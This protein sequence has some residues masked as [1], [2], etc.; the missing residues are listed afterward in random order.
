V[1]TILSASFWSA[2]TAKEA[3]HE[4]YKRMKV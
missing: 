4:H 1:G 3:A 2:W